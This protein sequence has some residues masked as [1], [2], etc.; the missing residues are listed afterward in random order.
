M[1]A[2]R[3]ATA[4]APLGLLRSPSYMPRTHAWVA[5]LPAATL[6]GTLTSA[7]TG[8]VS[9]GVPVG[10]LEWLVDPRVSPLTSLHPLP[11]I[12]LQ[13]KDSGLTLQAKHLHILLGCPPILGQA[14]GDPNSCPHRISQW[15]LLGQWFGDP[16]NIPPA[17][18]G[19]LTSGL[20]L[21]ICRL[22]TPS[23]GYSPVT[24]DSSSIIQQQVPLFAGSMLPIS[25]GS[26]H[27]SSA[28]SFDCHR[29][30][31]NIQKKPG[32]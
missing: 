4:A 19:D 8:S 9:M 25:T 24:E 11:G 2:R 15:C 5:P 7:C 3:Q 28:S 14:Q 27:E 30:L 23:T 17:I 26:A 32:P 16:P 10:M 22:Q 20:G 1:N 6:W 29:P 13:N 21:G 18:N 31:L 12:L